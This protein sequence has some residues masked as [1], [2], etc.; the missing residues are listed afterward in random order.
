MLLARLR[1]LR[2]V[3]GLRRLRL[4]AGLRSRGLG[5]RRVTGG[6]RIGG[7]SGLLLRSVLLLRL[8]LLSLRLRLRRLT[9]GLLALLGL[10]R[11]H[12]GLL[13]ALQ[14]LRIHLH[15]LAG[16][17]ALLHLLILGD[18]VLLLQGD[19]VSEHSL[20]LGVIGMG[21]HSRLSHGLQLSLVHGNTHGHAIDADLH[22]RMECLLRQ[23]VLSSVLL[24]DKSLLLQHGVGSVIA[25]LALLEHWVLR[26]V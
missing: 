6:L 2:L 17:P 5:R 15:G 22:V 8:S 19:L 9:R 26:R 13:E 20:S 16:L 4:L 3:L 24:L 21:L 14:L 7:L 18:L 11:S 25:E 12:L 1:S 10:H 23:H